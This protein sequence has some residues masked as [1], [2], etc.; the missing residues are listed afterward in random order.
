MMDRQTGPGISSIGGAATEPRLLE[1]V[2]A[3]E[4]ADAFLRTLWSDIQSRNVDFQTHQQGLLRKNALEVHGRHSP[5]MMGLHWG[6]TPLVAREVGCELLPSFA[7]FRM[8]FHDDVCRVHSDRP[9]CEVSLSVT[10]GYSDG[11]PWDLSIGTASDFDAT[12]IDDNF[13]KEPFRSYRMQPGDGLLYQ[14]SRRRHGRIVPN[15][16]RWSAH[17]FLQWID[18]AGPHRSEAFER[19]ALGAAPQP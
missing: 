6:L 7:Y 14:G 18:P 1:R 4:I 17:L 16:N 13:G 9:A 12:A 2:I 11:R 5:A 19:L 3:P 8:Y 15:P 10:I